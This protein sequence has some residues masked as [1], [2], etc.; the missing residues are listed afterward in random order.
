M[1]SVECQIRRDA[2]IPT[3]LMVVVPET[4][5]PYSIIVL[6]KRTSSKVLLCRWVS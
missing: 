5:R 1:T 4:A 2:G 3:A 6:G